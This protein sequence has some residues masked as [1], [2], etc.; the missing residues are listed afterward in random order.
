MPPITE[1]DRYALLEKRGRGRLFKLA[2]ILFFIVIATS[3]FVKVYDYDIFCRGVS[4]EEILRQ[5]KIDFQNSL[6]YS[7]GEMVFENESWLFDIF[8]ALLFRIDPVNL[9]AIIFIKVLIYLSIYLALFL[10]IG[11]NLKPRITVLLVLLM[12]FYII[13]TKIHFNNFLL[14]YLFSVIWVGILIKNSENEMTDKKTIWLF[15]LMMILWNNFH[16]LCVFGFLIL[17]SAITD[18]LMKIFILKQK[19]R[20]PYL[21]ELSVTFLLTSIAA[22]VSPHPGN[23]LERLYIY[24]FKFSGLLIPTDQLNP[25]FFINKVFYFSIVLGILMAPLA[26]IKK[27]YLSFSLFFLFGLAGLLDYRLIGIYSLMSVFY[28]SRIFEFAAVQFRFDHL[29]DK[30]SA[31]LLL[32]LFLIF[33]TVWIAGR[34]PKLGLGM[35]CEKLPCKTA[36]FIEKAQLPG[37]F[38]NHLGWGGYLLWRLYPEYKVFWD[39]RFAPQRYLFQEIPKRGFS[40]YLFEKGIRFAIVPAPDKN[41]LKD[42]ISHMENEILEDSILWRPVSFENNVI[43]LLAVKEENAFWLEKHGFSVL[44]YW[45]DD[46]GISKGPANVDKIHLLKADIDKLPANELFTLWIKARF[47]ILTGQYDKANKFITRCLKIDSQSSE[48][49]SLSGAM[50]LHSHM[51]ILAIEAYK[52]AL[53]YSNTS[54]GWA[55]LGLAYIKNNEKKKAKKA[56]IKAL[57]MDPQNR[58]ALDN[59]HNLSKEN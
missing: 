56:F 26:F 13:T 59:L 14:T 38:Y 9:S 57:K 19:D 47:A 3:T 4:G 8:A 15:P 24:T 41:R 39:G 43:V 53:K 12:S 37:P 54:T 50:L 18:Q 46:L 27:K 7:L 29:L 21:K 49:H 31:R 25:M 51:N 10:A 20:V 33:S 23:F 6:N 55:N 35:D 32:S 28:F 1:Q 45:R 34:G 52:T 22:F 42:S 44:R 36:N 48:C 16:A 58:V 30:K 11:G 2:V 5:G 17:G 40:K